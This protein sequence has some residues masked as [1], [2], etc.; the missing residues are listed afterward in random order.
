[1]SHGT[2]RAATLPT[3]VS[4]IMDQYNVGDDEAMKMFYES[5]IGEC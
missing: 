5:H 1:M 3:I 4:L 2:M